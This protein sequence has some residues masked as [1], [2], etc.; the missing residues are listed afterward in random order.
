MTSETL[1]IVLV[2]AFPM[3][4]AMWAPQI[5]AIS[6]R[7]VF[8]P[9]L[10]AFDGHPRLVEPTID[11]YAR[12]MLASLDRA[13]V[14]RAVFC[15]LS[16]GGYV[17]FGILRQA[18]DRV[19]GLVLADTRTSVDTPERLAARHRSIEKVRRDGP[20]AIADEMV[21][22]L[23]SATTQAH[24]PHVAAEVRRLIESQSADAIADGLQA[25]ITRPDSA[26]TLDNV[27]VPTL[28]IVGADDAITPVTD[29]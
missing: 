11:G 22:G 25:M 6:D 4:P 23:L 1:P 29:A 28:V 21:P 19:G 17:F 18:L 13:G 9:P 16:L 15:G 10:P 7:Q 14:S 20:R 12:D 2:H 5:E 8:A 26:A 3:G 24:R 27:R